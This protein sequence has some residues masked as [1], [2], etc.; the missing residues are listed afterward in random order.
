LQS[1]TYSTKDDTAG[2]LRVPSE[3]S[4]EMV[5]AGGDAEKVLIVFSL[6]AS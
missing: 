4:S 2:M 1:L 3:K 5:A 6:V